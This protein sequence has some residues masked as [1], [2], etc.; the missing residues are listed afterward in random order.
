MFSSLGSGICADPTSSQQRGKISTGTSWKVISAACNPLPAARHATFL[1]N[2]SLAL[3][4]LPDTSSAWRGHGLCDSQATLKQGCSLSAASR[5]LRHS[6]RGRGGLAA[7]PR[8]I[9]EGQNG[10]EKNISVQTC[11]NGISF[12]IGH[13]NIYIFRN[14]DEAKKYI[15]PL[16]SPSAAINCNK[17]GSS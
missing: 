10:T 3:C 2:T 11:P 4:W 6:L 1:V 15:F 5:R 7:M 14:F 16:L 13:L 9:K 17:N 12:L 8:R